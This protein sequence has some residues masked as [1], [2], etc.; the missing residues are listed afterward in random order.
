MFRQVPRCFWELTCHKSDSRRPRVVST[1][2]EASWHS[3]TC[4]TKKSGGG[5]AWRR[6]QE[7]VCNWKLQENFFSSFQIHRILP[8]QEQNF[9]FFFWNVQLCETSLVSDLHRNLEPS[10]FYP[11]KFKLKNLFSKLGAYL[12]QETTF[13][14]SLTYKHLGPVELTNCAKASDMLCHLFHFIQG[15]LLAFTVLGTR[16]EIKKKKKTGMISI[17]R[18]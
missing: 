13:P 10:C 7:S 2:W 15:W 8:K 3:Q 17:L 18:S 12:H 9:F 16:W 14:N 5:G 4:C 1:Y 11:N 6:Y